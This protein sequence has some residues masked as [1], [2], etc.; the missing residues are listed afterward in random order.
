MK[1]TY[2][3]LSLSL[4][5]QSS[6]DLLQTSMICTAIQNRVIA[7]VLGEI[8]REPWRGRGGK[9]SLQRTVDF[10]FL[11]TRKNLEACNKGYLFARSSAH[12]QTPRSVYVS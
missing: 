7:S 12:A 6:Y 4:S 11:H 5:L 10:M 1:D 9:A 8:E 3:V 2:G